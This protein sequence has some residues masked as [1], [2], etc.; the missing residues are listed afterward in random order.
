[1]K[2][3]IKI[4][5]VNKSAF[6][7]LFLSRAYSNLLATSFERPLTASCIMYQF[8]WQE[9]INNYAD[10]ILKISF[11]MCTHIEAL[12]WAIFFCTHLQLTGKIQRIK[13]LSNLVPG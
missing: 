7:Y 2:K 3:Q 13:F 6:I 8:L 10:T 5:S 12:P 4:N 9:I 1:M 11:L